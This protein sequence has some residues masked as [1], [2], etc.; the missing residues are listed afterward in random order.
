MHFLYFDDDDA[1][2]VYKYVRRFFPPHHQQRSYCGFIFG[3][4]KKMTW[5]KIK[6]IFGGDDSAKANIM[7][8]EMWPKS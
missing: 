4:L 5:H 6:E 1:G 8:F 2:R 3:S 7:M